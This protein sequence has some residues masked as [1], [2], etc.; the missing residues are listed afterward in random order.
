MKEKTTP[1]NIKPG[2]V[3]ASNKAGEHDRVIKVDRVEGNVVHCTSWRKRSSALPRWTKI[4]VTRFK[5][6][7]DGYRLL[8][9]A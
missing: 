9:D 7:A 1:A 5:P 6:T 2:Q 8:E 4:R 3:W